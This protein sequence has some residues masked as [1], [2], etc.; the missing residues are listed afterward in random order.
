LFFVLKPI[1]LKAK[2]EKAVFAIDST[3]LW[4]TRSIW[5]ERGKPAQVETAFIGLLKLFTVP[6]RMH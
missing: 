2:R 6:N 5:L 4:R 3:R 1:F